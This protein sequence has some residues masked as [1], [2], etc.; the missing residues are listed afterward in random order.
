MY[1]VVRSY[2]SLHSFQIFVLKESIQSLRLQ[3]IKGTEECSLEVQLMM[4]K[5]VISVGGL[6]DTY[7]IFCLNNGYQEGNGGG[8]GYGTYRQ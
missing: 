1:D 7:F 4:N 6:L 5:Q 8:G 2:Q 3:N